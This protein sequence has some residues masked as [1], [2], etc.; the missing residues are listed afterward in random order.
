MIPDCLL[1]AKSPS[2]VNGTD[3]NG[4]HRLTILHLLLFH[5]PQVLQ[6]VSFLLLQN[7]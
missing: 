1:Y 3:F 4:K 5:I 6:I 2:H 7:L